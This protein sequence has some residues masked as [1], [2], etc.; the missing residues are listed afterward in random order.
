MSE[1]TLSLSRRIPATQQEVWDVISDIAGCADHISGIVE[2]ELLTSEPV[3]VGTRWKETRLLL[4]RRTSEEMS[5]T[6]FEPPLR[7]V[8]EAEACGARFVSELRCEPDGEG[9][10]MLSMTMKTTPITFLARLMK[11]IAKLTMATSR[12]MIEQDLEDIFKACTQGDFDEAA[13]GDEPEAA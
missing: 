2:V 1:L 5:M 3:G 8:V 11:P 12:K 7:Y 9:A 6:T 4:G 13:G 10:T